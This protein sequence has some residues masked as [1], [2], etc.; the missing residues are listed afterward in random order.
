MANFK[1]GK[2]RKQTRHPISNYGR[3]FNETKKDEE[4]PVNLKGKPVKKH[5]KPFGIEETHV[6]ELIDATQPKPPGWLPKK[7]VYKNW[8][9]TERARNDAMVGIPK[10]EVNRR[11]RNTRLVVTLKKIER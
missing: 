6:Y 8:Y 11:F 1:R 4:R 2:P 7:Y 10:S 3:G 5:K 9:A